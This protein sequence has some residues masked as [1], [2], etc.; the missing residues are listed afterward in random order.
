MTSSP[1]PPTAQTLQLSVHGCEQYQQRVKPGLSLAAARAELE[2]LLGAG[3][4]TGDPPAWLR[5]AGRTPYYLIISD[6]VALPTPQ[7]GGWIAT[8]CVTQ[9]TLTQTRR[10]AKSTQRDPAEPP[11]MNRVRHLRHQRPI[12]PAVALLEHHQ[13]HERLQR[14]RRPTLRQHQPARLPELPL[15]APHQ[16]PQHLV[17]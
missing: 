15:P 7:T 17:I 8:T 3:E 12:P 11:Q 1:P 9:T 13:P 16:R 2:Q 4:I 10:A 5:S 14:D 6:A